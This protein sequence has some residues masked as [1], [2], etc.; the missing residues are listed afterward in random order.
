MEYRCGKHAVPANPAA[1]ITMWIEC[2]IHRSTSTQIGERFEKIVGL[3]FF[4]EEV[5][6]LGFI[7]RHGMLD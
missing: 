3:E 4:G 6:Q 1:Q 7:V 2:P 5:L